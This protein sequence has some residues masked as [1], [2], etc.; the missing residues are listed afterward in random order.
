MKSERVGGSV[1][2]KDTPRG[3]V[4]EGWGE[5]AG[6]ICSRQ[7]SKMTPKFPRPGVHILYNGLPLR[8]SRMVSVIRCHSSD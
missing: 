4:E 8:M 7:H 6:G 5:E 2:L 3:C 1:L